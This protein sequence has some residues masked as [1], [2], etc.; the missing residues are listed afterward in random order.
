M[1]VRD[2]AQTIGCS[3]SRV[4][5]W[6]KKLNIK[7]RTISE[8]IFAKKHGLDNGFHISQDMNA[9]DQMLFGLGVGIFWGE[10]NKRNKHTVR[11]G[12]S[13]PKL[14]SVFIDFLVRICGVDRTSIRF[15]LQI[16]SD[17]QPQEALSFW[18]EALSINK[19]QV[20]PTINCIKSGKIGT[21]KTKSQYGVMT[22]YVFNM[23]LRN[24]LVDQMNVPR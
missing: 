20:M 3:S 2:I 6:L 14:L 10:G 15:S 4:D 23:K 5:Y 12:N 19:N 22:V 9:A 8:A 13:D 1:S 7:K 16:F 11:V 18:I 24:W 21:Y 17:I